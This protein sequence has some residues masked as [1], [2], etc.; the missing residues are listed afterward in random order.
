[1]IATWV[2]IGLGF[3][4]INSNLT[5]NPNHMSKVSAQNGN[6]NKAINA[7]FRKC[8]TKLRRL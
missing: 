6:W 3:S 5:T 8:L 7:M 2:A 4:W 1:M